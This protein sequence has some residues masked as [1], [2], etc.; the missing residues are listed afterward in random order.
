MSR[1]T[2]SPPRTAWPPLSLI[3]PLIN[4]KHAASNYALRQPNGN[5][6]EGWYL[7]VSLPKT[8]ESYAFMFAIEA[9]GEGTV[10]LLTPDDSLYVSKLPQ[11]AGKFY[12]SKSRFDVGHW[13]RKPKSEKGEINSQTGNNSDLRGYQ[14]SDTS[15]HGVFDSDDG[16]VSSRRIQWGIDYSPMLTWGTR[17]TSRHTSTWLSEFGIFEPGYQV[18]MAHG[19]I[20]RGYIRCANK[21]VDVSG[22]LVYCEKNWGRSFP[23]RWWWVQANAF[24]DEPDLCILALGAVRNVLFRSETIGMISVHYKG[25]MYEFAPWACEYVKWDVDEWGSWKASAKALAGHEMIIE[26]YTKEP[27]V[28]VL[29]PSTGGMVFN[30]RDCS[31]G[32]LTATLKDKDGEIILD[33]IKCRNAQV[34]VGGEW[35]G[36]W[37]AEVPPFACILR[38]LI[39]FFN[40]PEVATT[41]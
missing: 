9:P 41:P 24:K 2:E 10:Q 35:D 23:R 30:V 6:F 37:V 36:R 28:Q 8:D 1:T 34:E 19:V 14:V 38:Y 5:F 33:H 26:A 18:L 31:R 4:S 11:A 22:G 27:P 7:R 21:E 3:P 32:E 39:H 13:I 29:G 40:G 20:T 12:G 15:S 25:K 16:R 17:G